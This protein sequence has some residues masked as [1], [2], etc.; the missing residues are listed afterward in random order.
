MSAIVLHNVWEELGR[1]AQMARDNV[2]Q[3]FQAVLERSSKRLETVGEREEYIDYLNKEIARYISHT[4]AYEEN[5]A[6]SKAISSF[7]QIAGN[8]ERIGDHAINLCEYTKRMEDERIT[9][10][11]EAMKEMEEMKRIS[12]QAFELFLPFD[13]IQRGNLQ[14][15]SV[16]EQRIDEMTLHNRAMQIE[17]MQDGVCEDNACI[18]YSEMLTDFERI[19]DHLLNIGQILDRLPDGFL[20]TETAEKTEPALAPV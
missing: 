12:L 3:S 18:L 16:L 2:E 7:F 20:E 9:F 6:D 8:L 13:Q 10:S 1:M 11:D 15:I 5:E 14:E 17:R 19:G 4:I